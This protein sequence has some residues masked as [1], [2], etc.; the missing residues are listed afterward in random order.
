MVII[1]IVTIIF[2]AENFQNQLKKKQNEIK[3]ETISSV[4]ILDGC[5]K[6]DHQKVSIRKPTVF[7]STVVKIYGLRKCL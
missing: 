1:M 7:F 4:S 6:K 5:T 3:R 2:S